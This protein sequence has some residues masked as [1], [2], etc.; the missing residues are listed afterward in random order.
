M[1]YK[2]N[3]GRLAG[4]LTG[5]DYEAKLNRGVLGTVAHWFKIQHFVTR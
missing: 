1:S 2:M 4:S 3:A 5:R